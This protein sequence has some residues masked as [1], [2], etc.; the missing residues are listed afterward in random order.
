VRDAVRDWGGHASVDS[1]GYLLVWDWRVYLLQRALS[2]IAADVIDADTEWRYT[3]F[4]RSEHWG[5][6]R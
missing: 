5:V 1:V 6:G 4:H 2:V 3:E